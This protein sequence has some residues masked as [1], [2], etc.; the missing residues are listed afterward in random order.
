M[1]KSVSE[2]CGG[3]SCGM[4]KR[5]C[6]GR[7]PF[8]IATFAIL[9]V[10]V[11]ACLPI[12]FAIESVASYQERR[13]FYLGSEVALL[14]KQIYEIKKLRE[15]IQQLLA[16]KKVFEALSNARIADVKLFNFL[17]SNV[18]QG[19]Q[20]VH[21]T[22]NHG[23]L[24]LRGLT[25]PGEGVAK[26]MRSMEDAQFFVKPKLVSMAEVGSGSRGRLQEFAIVAKVDYSARAENESDRKAPSKTTSSKRSGDQGSS[27]AV[28][29]ESTEANTLGWLGLL[30]GG[31]GLVCIFLVWRHKKSKAANPVVSFIKRVG[32]EFATL[33]PKDLSTWGLLP[34]VAVLLELSVLMVVVSWLLIAP[35]WDGLVASQEKESELKGTFHV[36]TRE[37]INLD[38]FKKTLMDAQEAYGMLLKALPDHHNSDEF[39]SSV[40]Q[41]AQKNGISIEKVEAGAESARGSMVEL[42]VQFHF[43]GTFDGLGN[44]VAD[45]P[46]NELLTHLNSFELFPDGA[47]GKK[48]KAM[49]L[50][51]DANISIYRHLDEAEL[52]A[53]RKAAKPAGAK[54]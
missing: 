12:Y 47:E 4:E 43:S 48:G 17:A 1:T 51:F 39:I 8:Y 22:F 54:K 15:E 44:L 42:P 40:Q 27:P 16:R 21:V 25:H 26:L 11:A 31:A 30:L 36:K 20:L 2:N 29:S 38:L 5:L 14:D 28:P 50:R 37:A 35:A 53:Q 6:N 3:F 7:K 46:K 52:A 13:N 45:L 24:E 18:P 32:A 19:V 9:V 34:R 10:A 49:K 33:D 41:S 23:M